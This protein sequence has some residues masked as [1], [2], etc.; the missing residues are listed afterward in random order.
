[1]FSKDDF[2]LHKNAAC[3]QHT[4]CSINV[5]LSQGLK[6]HILQSVIL[7]KMRAAYI[8]RVVFK[9]CFSVLDEYH[10]MIT[11]YS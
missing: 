3:I 10:I 7:F 1:M 9:I 5:S 4:I 2:S 8:K 6:M 11:M